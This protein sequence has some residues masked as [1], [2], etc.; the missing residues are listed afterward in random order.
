MTCERRI[1]RLRYYTGSGVWWRSTETGPGVWPKPSLRLL[2][3]IRI[4][5]TAAHSKLSILGHFYAEVTTTYAFLG[6][7]DIRRYGLSRK[8]LQG[9]A[10]NVYSDSMKHDYREKTLEP[11]PSSCLCPQG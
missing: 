6:A 9:W 10:A 4:E 8:P 11:G 3:R 1:W 2:T 5:D 7:V